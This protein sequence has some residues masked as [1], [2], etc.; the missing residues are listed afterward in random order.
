MPISNINFPF[1]FN[2]DLLFNINF[3]ISLNPSIPAFKA[4]AG[5]YNLI[6]FS[7]LL[8]SNLLIY[9][10]LDTIK[11]YLL[12]LNLSISILMNLTLFYK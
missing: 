6:S 3:L 8:K 7:N 9:G 11:S 4:I 1:S 12:R 10:G 2:N 5:S